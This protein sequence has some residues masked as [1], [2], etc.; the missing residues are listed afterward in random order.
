MIPLEELEYEAQIAA[1][2][3]EATLEEAPGAYKDLDTVVERQKGIVINVVDR[4]TPFIN[5]K[6][7]DK[8]RSR[9]DRKRKKDHR[10]QDNVG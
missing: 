1:K 9:R 8:G 2:V 5:V 6:G 3:S 10:G 4:V 7:N